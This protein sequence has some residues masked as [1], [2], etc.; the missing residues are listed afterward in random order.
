M[1]TSLPVCCSID[2][3]GS[4]ESKALDSGEAGGLI[5]CPDEA[6][7]V[8]SIVGGGDDDDDKSA[9]PVATG[10]PAGL[11]LS[12][13]ESSAPAEFAVLEGRAVEIVLVGSAPLTSDELN[14]G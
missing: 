1:H 9:W 11:K 8:D 12:A 2:A 5:D 3:P 6:E 10:A 13:T 14:V 4:I 7:L